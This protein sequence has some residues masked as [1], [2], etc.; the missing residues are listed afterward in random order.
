MPQAYQ[1][2]I[3]ANAGGG[4]AV[5]AISTFGDPITAAGQGGGIKW[6]ELVSDWLGIPAYNPSIPDEAPADIATRQGGLAPAVTVTGDRIPATTDPVTVTA[7]TPSNGWITNAPGNADRGKFVGRL[8]GVAGTLAHDQSTGA[9]T[10]TRTAAGTVAIPCPPGSVFRVDASKSHRGDIQ[11]FWGGRNGSATLLRD[12]RSMRDY[13]TEPKWFLVLSILTGGADTSGSAGHTDITQRN[14]QLATEFGAN[15]FDMRHYLIDNGL[16]DAGITPTAQDAPDI[17]ADTVPS[18]LR[19]DNV[20]PNATGHWVIARKI[21]QLIVDKGWVDDTAATIPPSRTPSNDP[22]VLDLPTSGA[23]A[24]MAA[25]TELRNAQNMSIRVVGHVD[26]L[27]SLSS[28]VR[29]STVT[30]DQRSWNLMSLS[31]Q[32]LRI[33]LFQSGTST[34]VVT[35]D[36]TVSPTYTPGD[37]LGLGVDVDAA[38]RSAMFYTSTDGTNW[39]QLGTAVTG[40]ATTIFAGTAPLELTGFAG[41]VESLR[42][43][44]VDGSV[45]YVDENFTDGAAIDW[46]LSGGAAVA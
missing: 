36:S 43:T 46:T 3:A 40:A 38:A 24:S 45:V 39:T 14:A 33:Q 44:S 9:W 30:G 11:T 41:D 21:A 37:R 6:H 28:I 13:L 17:A 29:R 25:S 2:Y 42:V 23:V 31:T 22:T 12:T 27:T 35:M 10:F 15:Y 16:S 8:C 19:D 5:A 32:R 34:P 18:S 1:D 20:H 7:I 26:S 4:A